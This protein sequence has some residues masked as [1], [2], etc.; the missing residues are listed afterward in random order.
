MSQIDRLVH[1]QRL[2]L[3]RNGY[4]GTERLLQQLYK[5]IKDWDAQ[6]TGIKRK[7][8]PDNERPFYAAL[9]F[10]P[11]G[12]QL[13]VVWDFGYEYKPDQNLLSLISVQASVFD[14][15]I[16]IT[17]KQIDPFELPPK[18]ELLQ[19]LRQT[20]VIT[21]QKHWHQYKQTHPLSDIGPSRARHH[22]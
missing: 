18:K 11:K 15:S 9:S 22:R 5:H 2:T 10:Q 19:N 16:R 20:L 21:N 1:M 14:V 4:T 13:P 6:A 8:L 3:L 7:N 12:G 17:N